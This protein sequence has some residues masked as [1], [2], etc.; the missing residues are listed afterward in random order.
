[1][2]K[3]DVFK[4][5]RHLYGAVITSQLILEGLRGGLTSCKETNPFSE[6]PVET[7]VISVNW[8]AEEQAFYFIFEHPSFPLVSEGAAVPLLCTKT[9]N[10]KALKYLLENFE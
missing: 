3:F 1:M 9:E 7:L 2:K 5:A 6:M 4:E 10:N 8:V